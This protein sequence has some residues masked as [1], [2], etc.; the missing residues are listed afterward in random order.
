MVAVCFSRCFTLS[1]VSRDHFFSEV[2][3]PIE[4]VQL[5]GSFMMDGKEVPSI[6]GYW[7]EHKHWECYKV[8]YFKCWRNGRFF[9]TFPKKTGRKSFF[10]QNGD[11]EEQ[12]C[13]SLENLTTEVQ[14]SSLRLETWTSENT[15][16]WNPTGNG[17]EKREHVKQQFSLTSKN[18]DNLNENRIDDRMNKENSM[19]SQSLLF[20]FG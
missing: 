11:V 3:Y 9:E 8:R 14:I 6:W 12:E 20:F 17:Q 18:E 16:P 2:T 1:K 10:R 13:S 5:D 19:P 15:V 7:C 4:P